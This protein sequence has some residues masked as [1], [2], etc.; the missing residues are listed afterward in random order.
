MR[1]P[2]ADFSLRQHS[3]CSPCCA[4]VHIFDELD[5]GL[6]WASNWPSRI[7]HASP[8]NFPPEAVFH[9][10]YGLRNSLGG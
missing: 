6:L 7:I 5:W 1:R 10:A 3:N 9:E 4:V 2:R 8:C